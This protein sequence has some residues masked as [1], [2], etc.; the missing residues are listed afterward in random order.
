MDFDV[1][2]LICQQEANDAAWA[3]WLHDDTCMV[4]LKGVRL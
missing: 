3:A 4:W 2:C 1:L